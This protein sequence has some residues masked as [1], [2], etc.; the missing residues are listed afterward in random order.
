M[1]LRKVSFGPCLSCM[2]DAT[3]FLIRLLLA[4]NA[5]NLSAKSENVTMELGSRVENQSLAALVKVWGKA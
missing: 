4:K 5:E 2:K 3:V 1:K